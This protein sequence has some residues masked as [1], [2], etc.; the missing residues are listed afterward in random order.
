MKKIRKIT[1]YEREIILNNRLR[2]KMPLGTLFYIMGVLMPFLLCMIITWDF[3]YLYLFVLGLIILLFVMVLYPLIY[4]N[5]LQT[6]NLECFESN[7]LSCKK[8][9][10]YFYRVEIEDLNN[11]FIDYR[12]PVYKRVKV[13]TEVVVVMVLG[14]DKIRRYLL[15]DKE[16]N[17]LLSSKKTRFDLI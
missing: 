5:H 17:K 10:I 13:G 4:Y 11:D 3:T 14:R 15:I 9:D 8:R 16:K 6:A 2:S 12:F 7:V 1:D